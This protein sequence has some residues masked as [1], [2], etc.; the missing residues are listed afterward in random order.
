MHH[1]APDPFEFM[2]Y[3]ACGWIGFWILV[4]IAYRLKKGKAILFSKV[5]GTVLFREFGN[6]GRSLTNIWG[7]LSGARSC[8][9]I[10]VTGDFLYIRP[11][12]PFNLMFMPELLGLEWK[13]PVNQILQAEIVK[14]TFWIG[15]RVQLTF[16]D[17]SGRIQCLELSIGNQE[18][19]LQSIRSSEVVQSPGMPKC[20]YCKQV[21]D[22]LADCKACARCKTLHHSDCFALNGKCS[23]FGCNSRETVPVKVP[24]RIR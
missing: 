21:F 13:I 16:Q 18:K 4:S 15:S 23:V 17:S 20:A 8:L 3:F 24:E 6:S 22:P 12:F 1:P 11:Y 14:K 9:V 10:T 7:G 5:D 19:F 2:M